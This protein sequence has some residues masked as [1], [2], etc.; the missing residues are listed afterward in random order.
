MLYL[1]GGVAWAHLQATS[2]CSSVPTPNVSNCAPGNYFSGT[3]GPAVITQSSTKLGWTLGTGTEMLLGSGWV[4]RGQYRYSDFGYLSIGDGS[5]F[6]FVD[7]RTCTGCLS[8]ASSPL[9]VS[10]QLRLMQHIFEL[11]LAY[12]F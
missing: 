3:L 4:A 10:Y 1:T 12:K 8:A 9:S 11:G 6:N 2:T 7:S 5:A